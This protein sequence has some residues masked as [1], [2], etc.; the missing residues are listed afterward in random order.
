MGLE[1][2]WVTVTDQQ[3]TL[4]TDVQVLNVDEYIADTTAQV[5]KDHNN[6]SKIRAR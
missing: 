3:G 1:P 6:R 5:P 2:L 4:V